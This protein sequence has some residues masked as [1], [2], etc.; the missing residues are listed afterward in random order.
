MLQPGCWSDFNSS[1]SSRHESTSCFSGV[2]YGTENEDCEDRP[3][4]GI[5]PGGGTP[6]TSVCSLATGEGWRRSHLE[7]LL[8]TQDQ[9]DHSPRSPAGAGPTCDARIAVSLARCKL[10]T[11]GDRGDLR[12]TV[13]LKLSKFQSH[14]QIWSNLRLKRKRDPCKSCRQQRYKN[15]HSRQHS[16][17]ESVHLLPKIYVKAA[18]HLQKGCRRFTEGHDDD[19]QNLVRLSNLLEAS[20]AI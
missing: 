15:I 5:P 6:S 11:K 12:T 8:I 17:Q 18:E 3:F 19:D 1:Y 14:G 20:R 9:H 7:S 13:L 2:E 10:L 16:R 4:D